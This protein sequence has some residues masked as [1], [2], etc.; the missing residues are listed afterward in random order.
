M[1][2]RPYD[3][4]LGR[5][6]SIDPVDGGSLNGYD[7]AAQDPINRFDLDGDDTWGKDCHT[8]RDKNCGPKKGRRSTGKVKI[9][10][11]FGDYAMRAVNAENLS[12]ED[13]LKMM[14][15][16]QGKYKAFRYTRSGEEHAGFW[17]K[18]YFIATRVKNGELEVL[19]VF[20]APRAYADRLIKSGRR[21]P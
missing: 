2:A 14:N 13:V 4:A 17:H 21:A 18:G 6:L 5:F 20:K 8:G 9:D 11:F 15:D 12:R 19:N 16:S 1:G 10:V 3:P 7:Y